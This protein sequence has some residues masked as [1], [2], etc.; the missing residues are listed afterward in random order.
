MIFF[1]RSYVADFDARLGKY[2]DAL[3]AAGLS[4]HFIGWNKDGSVRAQ[5]D[6]HTL[7]S[8]RARL[9]GGWRNALALVRWNV[10]LFCQLWRARK[11]LR[12]V[13]A[14]DLDSAVASWMFCAIARKRLVFDIYDKYTA[15]RNISGVVGRILDSLE[16][17]I[18]K[19]AD[20]TLIVSEERYVQHGLPAGQA[21]V[22]VLENVP[23]ACAHGRPM[24][25]LSSPWMIGY[26]GVLE[27]RN[28]GLEDLLEVCAGRSDV[29]LHVAGYGG[30]ENMFA[31]SGTEFSNIH[32]YGAMSSSAGLTLMAS[33]DVVVGMYYLSVPNHL[34][35]SPNKYYEHLML[36]RGMLTT[37]GTP[38]GAKV[39]D[40][41]TGWA[42]SEGV[43]QSR[44]GWKI[45][46]RQE[47]GGQRAM[48]AG[49][50]VKN[51][52]P[53]FL[54][55]IWES[56][57]GASRNCSRVCLDVPGGCSVG[58]NSDAGL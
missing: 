41:D 31:A 54:I 43:P 30:L 57:S 15:V 37:V 9:G 28:R 10:F 7:F 40:L 11:N 47:L 56:T 27:P 20:L 38:P 22:L 8:I 58:I 17:R 1:A 34:Y 46:I 19:S 39:M 13:H 29:E 48:R 36:G 49:Y 2:F 12:I 50:G 26:F 3:T 45:W 33:M 32:F 42:I 21:N 18:A 53:I 6:R 52:P 14:V 25:K 24:R 23:N 35:A 16:T 5:D 55:N 51:T 44:R 4:Y